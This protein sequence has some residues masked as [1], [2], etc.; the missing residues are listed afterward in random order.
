LGL[1]LNAQKTRILHTLQPFQGQAGFDFLSFTLCQYPIEPVCG[2]S[3]SYSLSGRSSGFSA[4]SSGYETVITPSDEAS[5]RHLAMVGQRVCQLQT[6]PQAQVI[7]ELN[8]LIGSWSAYYSGIVEDA[9][10]RRY[11]EQVEQLLLQWASLRYP[12][13]SRD[14]LY[15]RYWQQQSGHGRVFAL[16]GG[17]AR[18]YQPARALK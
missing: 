5:R 7:R 1:Q 4:P 2:K 11:D 15:G 3:A 8:P 14:W 18:R 10:L 9:V 16:S 13:K 6:A 17:A 12:G